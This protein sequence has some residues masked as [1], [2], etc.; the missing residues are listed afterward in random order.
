MKTQKLFLFGLLLT[1]LIGCDRVPELTEE[2]L[3][4]R[5]T[6]LHGTASEQVKELIRIEYKIIDFPALETLEGE[7]NELGKERWD[8]TPIYDQARATKLLCKR[9]P[10]DFSKVLPYLF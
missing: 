1:V 9:F 10:R 2:E 6:K 7:L 4:S 3:K 8:C 5:L